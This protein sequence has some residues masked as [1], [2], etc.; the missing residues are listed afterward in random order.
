MT[1]IDQNLRVVEAIL[2]ASPTPVSEKA[3]AERLPEGTDVKA[4]VEELRR[5]YADRGVNLIGVGAGWALRTA[6]DL[7][8]RLKAYARVAR[9][10][11]RAAIET[12]AIIAY[13]QPVTKAEI[14]EVRG[15]GLSKGTLDLLFEAGWIR[16]R[17]RRKTPGRPITWGTTEAFL[18]HFGLASLAD[19][20]GL[21][22]LKAA[23]LLERAPA[24]TAYRARGDLAAPASETLLPEPA[25]EAG[26]EEAPPLD[27]EDRE[28]TS[29][30]EA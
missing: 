17:G 24:L 22:E 2:F 16:P 19:L 11:S 25:P 21:D 18:D 8:P 1:A 14:E 9:K 15:V 10:L 4:L 20:P 27:P 12:L 23:G 13:H 28:R 5:H 6:P 3:L 7:A 26:G 29:G 30:S